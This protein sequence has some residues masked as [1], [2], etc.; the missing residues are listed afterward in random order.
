MLL[1]LNPLASWLPLGV[2]LSG[3]LALEPPGAPEVREAAD[4]AASSP[5]SVE[6]APPQIQPPKRLAELKARAPSGASSQ[7]AVAVAVA[8]TLDAEGRVTQ[9]EVLSSAGEPY[10]AEA[11]RILTQVPYEPARRDGVAVSARFVEVVVF[12]PPS[13]QLPVPPPI[14]PLAAPPADVSQAPARSVAT[15]KQNSV[16]ARSPADDA[17]ADPPVTQAVLVTGH[18]RQSALRR[19]TAAIEVV[20][21]DRERAQAADLGEVLARKTSTVVRREAGLG[22]SG[23]LSIGG[24]AGD[25]VRFFIDGVPLE[26][27]PYTQG[28][29]N[30]PLNFIDRVEV[31]SG[32]VPTRFGADAIGGAVHVVTQRDV[33]RNGVSGSYELGS[34]GTQRVQA[35]AQYFNPTLGAFARA[36]AFLDYSDNSYDVEVEVA[37]DQ[38]QLQPKRLPRFHDAY[39]GQGALLEFGVVD[40]S[41]ADRLSLQGYAA[42][43]DKELQSNPWMTRPY[44]EVTYARDGFGVNLRHTKSLSANLRSETAVGY[45]RRIT[46][47][48]DLSKCRYDWYGRCQIELPLAGELSSVAT[49]RSFDEDA[50]FVRALLES[51]LVEGHTLRLALAPTLS[52]RKGE[53][54]RL[55][56]T[57]FD[58]LSQARR[59]T[60]AVVGVEYESDWFGG[61]LTNTA[62]V[63]AYGQWLHTKKQVAASELVEVSN[64]RT[65]LGAGDTL[66]LFVA[67]D[68]YLKAA[69]ERA[70]RLPNADEV[71][72]DGGQLQSNPDLEPERGHNFNLGV[73]V[74]AAPVPFGSVH[75][76]VTGIARFVDDYFGTFSDGFS[77]STSNVAQVRVLGGE[78]SAGFTQ[79]RELFGVD[80]RASYLDLRNVEGRGSNALFEGDRLP[81]QPYLRGSG[82][83]FARYPTLLHAGDHVE[84]FWNLRYV[85]EYLLGWESAAVDAER[86]DVPEQL[87]M[88]AGLTYATR[89]SGGQLSSTLEVNN[90]TD[91]RVYD[92]YGS[93]RPGRAFSLKLT[94]DTR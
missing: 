48:R 3:S 68:V 24:L 66:R 42:S 57:L 80:A 46:E 84:L 17:K 90:F 28:L 5:G 60:H 61:K 4:A 36:G 72:G 75:A 39:R 62:F 87:V 20:E 38:G 81:N 47:F 93:Q 27:S 14:P 43:Y 67:D 16:D 49:D 94:F 70:A 44:G 83:A 63:K 65:L 1:A 29:S 34:F 59:L 18:S 74:D 25:R 30:I 56:D 7:V 91:E 21:L 32:V 13:I 85:H 88:G 37:N 82:A 92:F 50:V 45:S 76:A 22:S 51:P 31:Y 6:S 12:E 89:G 55:S 71:F 73:A 40:K 10:D 8:V 9:L 11:T 54:A 64:D 35:G 33:R 58:E 53:D 69:Y 26:F 52:S 78:A 23:Q 77:Y 79:R 41:W 86:K 15:P 2:L 19:S